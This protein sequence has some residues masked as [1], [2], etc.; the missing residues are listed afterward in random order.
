MLF[1]HELHDSKHPDSIMG[2]NEKTSSSEHPDSIVEGNEKTSSLCCH[3]RSTASEKSVD[4]ELSHFMLI[5]PS[6]STLGPNFG[7]TV[8]NLKLIQLPIEIRTSV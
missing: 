8:P 6:K 3:R 7:D 4:D 5:V 1:P 2:G